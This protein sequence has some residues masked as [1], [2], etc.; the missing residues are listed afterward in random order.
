M[1]RQ[2]A[3]CVCDGCVSQHRNAIVTLNNVRNLP[4]AF[5]NSVSGIRFD[6]YDIEKFEQE[7]ADVIY[8]DCA[9][10]IV[11]KGLDFEVV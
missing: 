8:T 4:L 11:R 7:I 2:V 10:T 3:E 9:I 6:G 5:P 1:S